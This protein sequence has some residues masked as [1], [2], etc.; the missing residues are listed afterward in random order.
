MTQLGSTRRSSRD[1]ADAPRRGRQ[2]AALRGGRWELQAI[3]CVADAI[4]PTS[5]AAIDAPCTRIGVQT[6]MITGDDARTAKAI[7]SKLG[8]DEVVAGVMPEGKVATLKRLREH[9]QNRFCR[10]R[11]QRR[12]GARRRRRRHRHRHGNRHCDRSRRRRADV[13]RSRQGAGGAG[14]VARDHAQHRSKICSGP[15]A[16]TSF[17]FPSRPARSIPS[18][19]CCC[20][21]CSAPA[22]WRCPASSY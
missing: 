22:P 4:K 13:R 15:S 5:L 20:R 16:I 10:R 14:A 21:P 19:A 6:A 17:S 11:R 2:V 8:I 7:A 18:T 12:A 1:T 9:Q 3:L